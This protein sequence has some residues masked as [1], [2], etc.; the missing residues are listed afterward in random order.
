MDVKSKVKPLSSFRK[1]PTLDNSKIQLDSLKLFNRLIIIVQREVTLESS[2]QYE[3]TPLPLSLFNAKDHKMNK[4]NKGEFSKICFKAL[5]GP[6]N[7]PKESMN[8]IV[9][10]G[11][12]LLYM[13]KWKQDQTW[14]EIANNYLGYV[15]YL[16]RESL[17]VVV[18]FDGYAM[19]PK[20]HDHIRRSKGLCCNVEIKQEVVNSIPKAKFLD[21]TNNKKGLIQLLSNVFLEN[22]IGVELCDNDA[23]TLKYRPLHNALYRYI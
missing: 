7:F 1:L 11:G 21:N 3:L 18:V 8:V 15:Q 9:I 16:G 4:A 14:E 19:S 12:W 17:N 5:I 22:D 6:V 23:D 20:D 13:V 2:L 10:D